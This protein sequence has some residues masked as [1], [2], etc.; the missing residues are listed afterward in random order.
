MPFDVLQNVKKTEPPDKPVDLAKQGK[1]DGWIKPNLKELAGGIIS[2]PET[3][4]SIANGMALWPIQK[5]FG[6]LDIATGGTAEDARAT[7]ERIGEKWGYQPKLDA[8]KQAV[9]IIGKGIDVAMTPAKMAGKSMTQLVG[10][11][12]GYLT[13]LAGELATFKMIGGVK[14]GVK[15]NIKERAVSKNMLDKKLSDLTKQERTYVNKIA[16]ENLTPVDVIK[17]KAEADK[18]GFE[19]A[20]EHKKD[21]WLGKR[22][23]SKLESNVEARLTQKEIKI[24]AKKTKQNP[25]DID[26]AIEIYIDSERNPE[27]IVKYFDE[28]KPEQKKI[29]KLSQN[30]PDYAKNIA[31]KIRKSYD[32]TGIEGLDAEVIYNTIEN[33]AARKWDLE[34]PKGMENVR[35]FGTKTG[36][37]KTRKFETIVEGWAKGYELKIK[38]ATE[39]LKT[40]K[41]EISNTIADKNFVAELQKLKDLEGNPL[42]STSELKGYVRVEHPNMTTW[43]N[44]GK[45][46][47]GKVYGKNVFAKE[48]GTLLE[49]RT[50]YAPKAQAKNINNILGI[51]KLMDIPGIPAITKFNAVT[52][53]W[54]LQSS[55]FHHQAFLRSYYLPGMKLEGI[56]PRQAMKQGIEAIEKLLPNLVHGVRNGLTLGLRQDWEEGLMR[57]KTHIG[58]ILDKTKATKATKDTINRFREAQS[59]WLFGELGAGLKAKAYLMEFKSQ[60]KKY[61]DANPDVIAKRVATLINEDFGGLHLQRIGRNPTAQHIFRL[62]ALAPDWTES[63]IRT[64]VKAIGNKTGNKAEL[65]LYRNFWGGVVV[66]GLGAT[67]LANYALA[68]GDVNEMLEKYRDAWRSGNYN[69]MKT[70]ITPIYE[71]L[72]GESGESKYFSILGHFQDVPKFGTK[73]IRSAKNKASVV[74]SMALEA[75]SGTDWAQRK[76]TTFE[77]LIKEGETVKWGGTAG[78]IKYEQFPSFFLA[79]LIGTQPV[80]FQNLIAMISGESDAFDAIARSAGIHI[81]STYDKGKTKKL[82]GVSNSKLKTLK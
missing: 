40:Y 37:S 43:K 73:P 74:S 14:E 9:D 13:E 33:F 67:A 8:T 64:M 57:E 69:W 15:T 54:I 66:K 35:K 46:E 72:G 47:E 41:N 77:D 6:V 51:S 18:T 2:T 44:A 78:P 31:E 3:I 58:R 21:E 52:K 55:L 50:L 76:F 80:Q 49:R 7:E 38:T 29:V 1:W 36:H 34:P 39:N 65:A 20:Y 48:D 4:Y 26:E 10:P 59:D 45:I 12:T 61:P 27:H 63:N 81:T 22:D 28:L 68:G 23:V 32:K 42:L 75:L 56:T 70:D 24:N 16:E 60:I 30:L 25:K 19:K 11:R 17:L 5:A 82:K 79:Q 71:A 62:A 53:G